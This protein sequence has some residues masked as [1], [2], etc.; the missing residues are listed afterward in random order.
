MSQMLSIKVR[1]QMMST[2]WT[3]PCHF[4]ALF[5]LHAALHELERAGSGNR[6]VLLM[7]SNP[8]L[9]LGNCSDLREKIEMLGVDL[10]LVLMNETMA[11]HQRNAGNFSAPFRCL[12]SPSLDIVRSG[13]LWE[14]G[15]CTDLTS[16]VMEMALRICF[17]KKKKTRHF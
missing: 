11:I 4:P 16:K 10:I 5:V 17:E 14:F 15:A 1:M 9:T 2:G 13:N 12:F 3:L 6:T 8:S 7:I